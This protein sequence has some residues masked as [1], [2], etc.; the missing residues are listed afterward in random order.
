MFYFRLMVR[1]LV[2]CSKPMIAAVN[3]PAVGFGVSL[4]SLCDIVLANNEVLDTS[5]DCVAIKV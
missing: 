2:T 1:L 4:A 5:Y 3:G